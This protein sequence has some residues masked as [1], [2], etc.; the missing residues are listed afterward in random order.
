MKISKL[1]KILPL[2]LAML[3]SIGY[4][5]A[6]GAIDG[7]D[8]TGTDP[9][10]IDYVLKLN[11]YIQI[12]ENGGNTTSEGTY[13]TNYSTLNIDSPLS[14]NFKVISNARSRKITL[15]APTAAT[16][17]P[18]GL[19]G[20]NPD[21]N[22][23]CLVF[24]N[25]STTVPETSV[26]SITSPNTGSSGTSTTVNTSDN[27]F[28]FKFNADKVAVEYG[29]DGEDGTITGVFENGQIDYTMTNGIATLNFSSE[30]QAEAS[31]FNTRDTQGNYK[32]TLILTDGGI[33]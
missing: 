7:E 19:Y 26:T 2:T 27:A 31:T 1:T 29:D 33:L 25:S 21:T 20:F 32:A 24:V 6:A 9:A 13:G 4:A 30:A 15:T 12:T 3:L 17:A 16:G 8:E 28:A 10:R 18:S 22:A 14:A 5:N 23:F 11:D